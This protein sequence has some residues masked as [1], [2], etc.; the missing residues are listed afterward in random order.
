LQVQLPF[1]SFENNPFF[2]YPDNIP[3]PDA[4]VINAKVHQA[5]NACSK[6]GKNDQQ[7]PEK[8]TPLFFEYWGSIQLFHM[9][10]MFG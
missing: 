9:L 6:D 5:V 4:L 1:L 10:I 3:R 8:M 7:V 2:A